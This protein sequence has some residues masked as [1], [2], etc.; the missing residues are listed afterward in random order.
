MADYQI[1]KQKMMQSVVLQSVVKSK[2][3]V[4]KIDTNNQTLQ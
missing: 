3:R 2:N 4:Q 1:E